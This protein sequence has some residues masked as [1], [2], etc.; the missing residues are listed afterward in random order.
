MDKI[1]IFVERLKK[2]GIDVELVG[3]Y[4]WI[5]LSKINGKSVTEKFHA[6]HGFTVAFYPIKKDQE[7]KFTD[8]GEIFKLLRKY[9]NRNTMKKLFWT[10]EMVETVKNMKGFDYEEYDR[11]VE[12]Q[13]AEELEK[14]N[15]VKK[16]NTRD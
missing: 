4:P 10:P 14:K 3:N 9:K 2:I 8:I 11:L 1:K 13:L 5:Y 12:K 6:N 15:E 16:P 7:L